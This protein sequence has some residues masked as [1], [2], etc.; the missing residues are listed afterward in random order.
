M[1]E[2]PLRIAIFGESYLPYL[3]GVTVSTEALAR[4][5]GDAGHEVLLV[6]PRPAK[7]M[8]PGTAGALGPDPRVEWLP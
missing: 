7:G 8:Q 5:L 1:S 6:V 2:R 4:G 3:S